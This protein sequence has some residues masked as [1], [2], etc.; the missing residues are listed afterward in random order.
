MRARAVFLAC[1]LLAMGVGVSS[2]A[3][4]AEENQE[5]IAP[6]S[7]TPQP[8]ATSPATPES[9]KPIVVWPTLTLAGDDVGGTAVHKP[10]PSEGSVYARAMELDA[11]L[12]DAVQDLGFTLDIADAGPAMG[13]A[14]DL[15]MLER[16]QH[17][18]SHSS[19][20]TDTGTWVVSA[21]LDQAAGDSYVLRIVVVP[22][23]SKQLRVRV[24]RVSG[25]DVSVRG[26]VLLRDL[27]ASAPAGPSETTRRPEESASTGIMAPSRS[28]G[29]AVLAVNAALFGAFM[30]FSVQR[31]SGSEDPRLLYP[32]LTLGTGVGLGSALLVAEEWNVSTGDA[33]T[34]AGGAWWGAASGIL[35][36]NGQ[37]VKPLTD[38]YAWGVGGGL[39]GLGL[40]TFSLT[41]EKSDEGD[42]VLVHSGAAFGLGLGALADFFYRGD[43][44]KTPY[45]GAGFGSA[46]GLIG[47]GGL[48]KLTKVSAS[49]V[50]LVDLG[51][52]L[53]A[54]AGAAVGSPLVFENVTEEKTRG[55]VAATFAGT[56]A[57][58][59]AAWWLTRDQKA[60]PPPPPRSSLRLTP[61]G[62]TIGS[63]PT[64]EGPV[65]AYGLGMRGT[66]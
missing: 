57:G 22:P 38:R 14:R 61:Y 5:A 65:P 6:P 21:R 8:P 11:T 40:A 52:G 64:R 53:G 1:A 27:L 62:G 13:H 58:G 24:E 42:A 63:S 66:W 33:W 37:K 51:A 29:R 56:L 49:R 31:A 36:A 32:L 3:R 30:A 25:A 45:T 18:S 41:R 46:I 28:P 12:R 59:V 47:G 60:A 16:A 44:E 55:F 20:P 35:I 7:S 50:L 17:A 48:A 43:L 4:A 34:L 26:L 23:K 2:V 15:D 9:D 54:L 10:G 19:S 39:L